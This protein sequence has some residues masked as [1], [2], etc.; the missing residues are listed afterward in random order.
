MTL[1]A[2][3]QWGEVYNAAHPHG[4][5]F[6]GGTGDTI[7]VGGY[8]T[9]GGHAPLSAFLGLGADH[10]LEMQVVT[11]AGQILTANQYENPNL[12]W[13]MRGVSALYICLCWC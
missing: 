13:A 2:G 10:I 3:E 1:A 9:G 6:I 7:G 5:T 12:F 8:L 4:L 11:A